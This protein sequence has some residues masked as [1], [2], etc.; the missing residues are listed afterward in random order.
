MDR[1]RT[2]V[3]D[4][5]RLKAS[6]D[7]IA[8]V[9]AYDHPFASLLDRAGVEV[10]LVGDTLGQVV[11][12]HS[13]TLAVTL[14]QIVYHAQLVTRACRSALVVGDLPFGS[15]QPGAAS[16]LASAVRLVKEAGV[17]AVKLEGGAPMAGALRAIAEADIPVMGHVGLTPQSFHRMGGYRVQGREA[18][19]AP[20]GRQRLLDDAHAV[21]Q[22]GAFAV[23]LEAI[24]MDL[25]AEITDA[26]QIPTIGIG[27]GPYCDGQVLVLH[28]LI[29]VS[30]RPPRFARR[31]AQVADLVLGAAA[32][33]VRD[34]KSGGFPSEAESYRGRG[35]EPTAGM[36]LGVP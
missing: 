29:G 25:A 31:Y 18:G 22:A 2:T 20:G 1:P 19:T 13:N 6:H 35:P 12:G 21:E 33:F 28:D 17:A 15:F 23:V 5:Q 36:P 26:L 34:V 24:P 8:M 7:R 14:D 9:T 16:A 3:P 4:L 11:Q 27:A 10:I 30:A 32:A